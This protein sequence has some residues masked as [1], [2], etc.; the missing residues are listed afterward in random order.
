MLR[1]LRWF[2]AINVH[3]GS[4]QLVIIEFEVFLFV[5]TVLWPEWN[6]FDITLLR[7]T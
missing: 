3:G 5:R 1:I 6:Y 2:S 7:R 4:V